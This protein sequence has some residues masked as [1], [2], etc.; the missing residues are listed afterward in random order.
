MDK[1]ELIT[2]PGSKQHDMSQS[3]EEARDNAIGKLQQL[4]REKSDSSDETQPS[5]GEVDADT[6]QGGSPELPDSEMVTAE[7]SDSETDS[8]EGSDTDDGTE[9]KEI[10]YDG[11]EIPRGK[12]P[13]DG[14]FS[15]KEID[16]LLKMS[17]ES[18]ILHKDVSL[19]VVTEN[20]L[21]GDRVVLHERSSD[22]KSNTAETHKSE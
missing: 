19:D 6:A 17:K 21:V 11:F 1:I 2:Q 18:G 13:L 9:S 4:V 14:H 3:S 5:G 7:G 15:T 8:A 16:T 10:D 12:I 20:Q 22:E